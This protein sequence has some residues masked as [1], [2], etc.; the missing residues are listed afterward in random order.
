MILCS[1]SFHHNGQ[2]P[3]L[4]QWYMVRENQPIVSLVKSLLGMGC[5]TEC[6]WLIRWECFIN[7]SSSKSSPNVLCHNSHSFGLECD[8]CCPI[9]W[10]LNCH[11]DSQSL[12]GEI[13]EVVL[14]CHHTMES[15]GCFALWCFLTVLVTWIFGIL[16]RNC[17]TMWSRHSWFFW[18]WRIS[19]LWRACSIA[20]SNNTHPSSISLY[21]TGMMIDAQRGKQQHVAN[22]VSLFDTWRD[23]HECTLDAICF[24]KIYQ[25]VFTWMNPTWELNENLVM[26]L[27]ARCWFELINCINVWTHLDWMKWTIACVPLFLLFAN[28]ISRKWSQTQHHAKITELQWKLMNCLSAN[29][30]RM[31]HSL[32]CLT[33]L[34]DSWARLLGMLTSILHLGWQ[35]E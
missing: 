13:V 23:H 9:C 32:A 35:V 2:I 12:H 27:Q 3:P 31:K 19:L 17:S 8:E 11:L 10:P 1:H 15:V 33:I 6:S 14:C 16:P 18:V 26:I 25:T 29:K 30:Q 20:V 28:A 7:C 34:Q 4:H 24:W 22:E 5:T 21:E